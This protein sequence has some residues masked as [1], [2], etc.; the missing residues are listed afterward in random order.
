[1]MFFHKVFI[2]IWSQNKVLLFNIYNIIESSFAY[3]GLD[4]A[5]VL[6]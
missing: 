1:M 6:G 2:L 4:L 5:D 3:V